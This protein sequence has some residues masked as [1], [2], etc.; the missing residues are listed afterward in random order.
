MPPEKATRLNP[1]KTANDTVRRAATKTNDRG[2]QQTNSPDGIGQYAGISLDT[3][4]A[5]GVRQ[6]DG[7]ERDDFFF[8]SHHARF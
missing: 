8:T 6:V 1:P 7:G 3:Q 5:C 2:I 4:T